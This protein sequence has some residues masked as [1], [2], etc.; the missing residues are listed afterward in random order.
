MFGSLVEKNKNKILSYY[1]LIVYIYRI[2]IGVQVL[3]RNVI[4]S[5][6][7]ERFNIA[8]NVLILH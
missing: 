8:L 5:C 4:L 7:I 6:V 3:N 1:N 2:E